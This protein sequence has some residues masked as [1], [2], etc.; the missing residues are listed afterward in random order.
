MSND[1]LTCSKLC[2][3]SLRNTSD[4]DGFYFNGFDTFIQDDN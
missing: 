3:T 4:S 2:A 1:K